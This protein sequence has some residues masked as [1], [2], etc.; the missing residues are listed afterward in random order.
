MVSPVPDVVVVVVLQSRHLF[1]KMLHLTIEFVAKCGN[2]EKRSVN[3]YGLHDYSIPHIYYTKWHTAASIYKIQSI[4]FPF[5][6]NYDSLHI[7]FFLLFF[8]SLFL[9]L[10]FRFL[11]LSHFFIPSVLPFACFVLYAW[12]EK[13]DQ[14][15][16]QQQ[17]QE[18]SI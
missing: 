18:Q 7:F 6:T 4:K 5:L 10:S 12:A 9:F 8:A 2:G 3:V 13:I 17:K 14:D 1:S 15:R 16:W 11:S